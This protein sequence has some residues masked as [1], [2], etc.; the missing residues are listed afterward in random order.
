MNSEAKPFLLQPN[1]PKT[2]QQFEQQLRE[3]LE[4]CRSQQLCSEEL[5]D[6]ILAT[7]QLSQ[8]VEEEYLT[9]RLFF[10]LLQDLTRQGWGFEYRTDQ[11]VAIPPG[12]TNSRGAD[13]AEIKQRLRSSLVAARDEQ[14]REPTTRRFILDVER[15]KWHRGQQVSVLN[16]FVSPREFA[17]DLKRRLNTSPALQQEL[18]RDAIKPYLQLATE[19]RDEFTNLRL[20][21]IWRYCRYTW[22]LPL[23]AQPGR[24]MFYLVRDSSRKFHPIIGIGALGSSIV[25]I[26]RRDKTIGWSFE[27]LREKGNLPERL[28]ALEAEIDRAIDEVHWDD[29]LSGEDV[30][31]PTEESLD[32]LS[33]ITNENPRVSQATERSK[34]VHL[35]DDTHSSL[36]RRKR[37]TELRSLLRAKQ[38]FHTAREQTAG[39]RERSEWLLAREEGRQALGV[40]LRN[41]KKRHVGVSMMDITTCGALPPYSEILGGKLVAL[42]MASPQVIADYQRRYKEAPSEIASRMKGEEIIRPSRLVLLGTTS[43]YYVGSSQYNRLRV[44]VANGEL[45]YIDI[46]KTKG[47][48][49]VHL[50]QRT[51]RT[52]QQLLRSHP[53]LEPESSMFAAGVNFKM[54]SVASGLAHLGMGRLQ[55]HETPR[56]VFLVPLAVNWREYLTGH[57][58]EPHY[59]YRDVERP[60]V[61][62]LQLIDFWKKRWFIPRAQRAQ[63]LLRL[64]EVKMSVRVSA[65]LSDEPVYAQSLIFSNTDTEALS[66][67]GGDHMSTQSIIPWNTLAE[68]K[69]QRISIAERLTS[70]ELEAIHIVTKLDQNLASLVGKGH[71]IYLSGNPGD[72][73]T[74]IIRRHLSAIE[75]HNVFVNLD[76][77]A[78]DE[79]ELIA[80]LQSAIAENRPAIVAINEGPLRRLLPRLPKAEQSELRLQLDRPYLYEGHDTTDYTA[81][82]LNLGSRQVLA[83]SIVNGA[84]NV[85]LNHVNYTNAPASVQYN[86]AMLRRPR[87]QERL[88][89]LL[90]LVARSGAHITMHELLGF[91]AFILTGGEKTAERAA[92]IAPYYQLVFHKNCPLYP[93]LHDLDPTRIV[94]PLV[95]MWLW[96]NPENQIEWIETPQNIPP[97]RQTDSQEAMATFQALKRRFYFEAK[98]GEK[99]LDMLPEDRKTF[100]ELLKDSSSARDTVKMRVLEA[101]SHFFGDRALGTRGTQLQIWTSLRY[102]ATEPP[103][104]FISS[105]IISAEKIN[106]H[107]P[108]LRPLAEITI[109]YEPSHVRLILPPT[110][111]GTGGVGLDI[112]LELWLALMKLK[113]G[114]S[115]RHHDPVI[116]RRLNHFMSRVA[117][118]F[119]ETQSGYVVIYVRD[120]ETAKTHRIEVSLEKERY[121]W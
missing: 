65:N 23:S 38:V 53:E 8:L 25:Q 113:R 115:Q 106:L 94:H 89:T 87:V 98:D 19:E 37:A 75:Q 84:L 109:E 6:T 67:G 54:R 5:L 33:T 95:D 100:Y 96:E 15:P 3:G 117:S 110:S 52:L 43:L 58:A 32:R 77:S 76:A 20:I 91:F 102:E 70:D 41:I 35:L 83:S 9:I 49:T 72:G 16:L 11:L 45:K 92:Q 59:I 7:L 27:S 69:D 118:Q 121:L 18:L 4:R 56:L 66:S 73:K 28:Q 99:L 90:N 71:R 21:D 107:V 79:D 57:D 62:T 10:E 86:Q 78:E 64:R 104:A 101:L 112:D 47:Y 14:L 111:T 105:Q 97:E 120:L 1:L 26:T 36:Y 103:T 61:E 63:T 116:G 42:L 68:L 114:T 119:Q 46:G 13:Q 31:Y 51:Y 44:P 34:A 2:A 22:S 40:A 60:E 29:L 108:R 17:D 74:H 82:L 85:V 50:S 39:D 93:W 30:L 12:A 55:K 81:L 48:G 88:S 80:G 24:Q